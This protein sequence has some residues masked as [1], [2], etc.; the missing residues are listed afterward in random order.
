MRRDAIFIGIEVDDEAAQDAALAAKLAETCPVDIYAD[1]GGR[2]E[3][4][5]RN[6]DECILCDMCL[7]VSPPDAV[8]V[9]TLYDAGVR[10]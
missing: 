9:H 4:V 1:A 6:I 7:H 8:R 3:I 10:A 5:E 2:V